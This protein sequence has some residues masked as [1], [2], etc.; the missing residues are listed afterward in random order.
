MQLSRFLARIV[1][2]VYLSAGLG[3]F[4]N[5]DYYLKLYND[6]SGSAGLTYLAG[7]MALIMGFLIVNYHN[8]WS[9]NW[10]VLITIIGWLSLIKGIVLIAFPQCAYN[11][12]GFMI[13][14]WGFKVFPYVAICLG[15]LFGYLGFVYKAAPASSIDPLDAGH[16]QT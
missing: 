12:S 6:M 16:K 4:F 10:T 14:G 15:I 2:V 5:A 3:A 11:L 9:R 13:T 8:R 1:A 7:F